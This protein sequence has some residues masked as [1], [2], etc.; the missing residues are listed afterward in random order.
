M[1]LVDV[2]PCVRACHSGNQREREVME[3]WRSQGRGC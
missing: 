3:K 2:R 1:A